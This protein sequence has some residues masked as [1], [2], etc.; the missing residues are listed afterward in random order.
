LIVETTNTYKMQVSTFLHCLDKNKKI[1]LLEANWL[2]IKFNECVYNN[3]I[4]VS[5]LKTSIKK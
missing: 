4:F 5:V 2:L 1:T 3:L